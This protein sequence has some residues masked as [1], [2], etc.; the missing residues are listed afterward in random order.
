MIIKA[1]L[2]SS[3][4]LSSFVFTFT[5]EL[6]KITRPKKASIQKQIDRTDKQKYD[7]P[8]VT[9]GDDSATGQKLS[10]SLQ[11]IDGTASIRR[12]EKGKTSIAVEFTHDDTNKA[13]GTAVLWIVTKAGMYT[14]VGEIPPPNEKN[15]S[16]MVTN[17]ELKELGL[18]VTIETEK[19]EQPKGKTYGAF[20]PQD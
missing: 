2:I 12:N 5:Q 6:P 3:I 1:T 19:T 20:K 17:V 18:F 4:I 14:K 13:E 15:I 11:G 16:A 8:M 7:V 10:T 9:V